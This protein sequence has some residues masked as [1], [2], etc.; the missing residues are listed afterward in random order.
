MKRRIR[1]ARRRLRVKYPRVGEDRYF[2]F[3]K[4]VREQGPHCMTCGQGMWGHPSGY[5]SKMLWGNPCDDCTCGSCG[6]RKAYQ[7]QACC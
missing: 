2:E 3:R 5:A 4:L 6:S 7:G 1:E